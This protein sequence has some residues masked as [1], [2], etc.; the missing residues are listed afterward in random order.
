MKIG[1][2]G[3]GVIGATIAKALSEE[4]IDVSIFDSKKEKAGTPPSG[5]H[6]SP[7]WLKDMSP[8]DYMPGIEMLEQVWG[9]HDESYR[10]LRKDGRYN[11]D[12]KMWRLDTDLITSFPSQ[13]INVKRVEYGTGM[14][15]R[16]IG[17]D[18]LG[19]MDFRADVVIACVGVWASYLFPELFKNRALQ[20]KQGV[21]FRFNKKLKQ[22][23]IQPWAPYKQLVMH[24][25]NKSSVW[26]GDGTAIIERNWTPER[27]TSCLTRC[28]AFAKTGLKPI[29][30]RTG[31]RAYCKLSDK[32]Q[33]CLVMRPVPNLWVITGAEKLGTIAAGIMANRIV[34]EYV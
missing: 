1:I 8:D 21:S 9:L 30:V 13:R 20:R 17:G 16:I 34:Q 7:D 28:Q 4:G 3:A 6:I 23:R 22:P 32:R 27:T 18:R 31:L 15:P 11:K 5:G 24:P 29:E 33:C 12:Q 14:K 25:Q 2:V 26:V 19:A 10:V